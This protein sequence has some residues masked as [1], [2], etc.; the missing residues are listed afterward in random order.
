MARSTMAALIAEL[1]G[2]VAAG[3][4]EYTLGTA[5]FWDDDQLQLVLDR[6]YLRVDRAPL[7][8]V[9]TYSGGTAVYQEYRSGYARMEATLGG[10]A[11]F[12]VEDGTGADQGTALWSADYGRGVIT[13]GSNTLGTAYYLSARAYDIY[14][15]AAEVLDMWSARLATE[16]DFSAPGHSY[17]RSQKY[18]HIKDLARQYR[19]QALGYS[20]HDGGGLGD[21]SAYFVR[22]DVDYTGW[23]W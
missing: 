4:A 14:G 20:A 6:H 21:G 10:T 7:T 22:S 13:F 1:R 17:K 5:N 8:A 2:L 11:L 16:F 18:A 19:S 9:P 15:A 23:G 3:S 12:I